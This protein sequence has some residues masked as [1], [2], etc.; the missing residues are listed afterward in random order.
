MCFQN[1]EFLSPELALTPHFSK[2]VV[3]VKSSGLSHVLKLWFGVSMSMLA[4][5]YLCSSKCSF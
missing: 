2:I 1:V 5:K 4:V 3:D